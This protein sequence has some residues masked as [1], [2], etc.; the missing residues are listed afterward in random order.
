MDLEPVDCLI[1][2]A[3]PAGLTAGL[4]LRRFHRSVKVVDGGKA[5][6]LWIPR[7]HNVP[8]FVDGIPGHELMAT[9][10][11]QFA[12]VGGRVVTAEV[13]RI[14]RVDDGFLATWGDCGVQARMVLLATGSRDEVPDWPSTDLLRRRGLLRQCPVCDGFDFS[15]QRIGVFGPGPRG[16]REA[17]FIRHFSEH[18]TWLSSDDSAEPEPELAERLQRAGVKRLCGRI[19]DAEPLQHA[20]HGGSGHGVRVRLHDGTRHRFDV[21]YAALGCHPRAELGAQLGAELDR[22]GNLK[23]DAKCRT[24]VPGLYAAGDITGGLDQ[25]VVAAGQ[26]AIAATGMHN[27]LP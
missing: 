14:E 22:G 4:Y 15:G 16:A 8:G 21:L 27:N 26:A 17:L 20:D 23:V 6:A 3:G 1:V 25:I 19:D 9:L 7:S 10:Y 13:E 12:D 5:R 11:R 2:G 18:L 24:T